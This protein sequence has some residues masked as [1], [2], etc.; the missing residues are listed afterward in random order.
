MNTAITTIIQLAA[1]YPELVAQMQ[2]AA[3]EEGVNSVDVLVVGNEAATKERTRILGLAAIQFGQEA[4][5]KFTAVVA[6]G[7]TVEQFQAITALNPPPAPAA[8]PTKGD[9][10]RRRML[11]AIEGVGAENPGPGPGSKG[12]TDLSSLPP[13]E[14]AKAQ[15][16]QEPAIR[17]EFAGDFDAFRA[18]SEAEAS[19]KVKRIFKKQ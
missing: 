12:E 13:R 17:E 4:S 3:R 9:E 15:W 19:G 1:A 10:T 14:R 6:S 18:F 5:D 8:P 16:D 7:V 11:T 2:Q